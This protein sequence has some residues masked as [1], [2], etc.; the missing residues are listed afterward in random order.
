MSTVKQWVKRCAAHFGIVLDRRI[1]QF[2][3]QRRILPT[4]CP[5]IVDIG[6]F[7]GAVVKKYR[8]HFPD[9]TI[10][11][12]EPCADEYRRLQSLART[13]PLII[14][15]RKAVADTVG[16]RVLHVNRYHQTNSLYEPDPSANVYWQEGTYDLHS[17]VSVECTT[18]D[19]LA[20]E[21]KLDTINIVKIDAQ[22]AELA[23]LHGAERLF[24]EGRIDLVY[25]EVITCPTYVGQASFAEVVAFLSRHDFD[26]WD[27]YDP[28]RGHGK[29]KSWIPRLLQA[30]ML[31]F[32]RRLKLPGR[33]D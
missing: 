17:R 26:L 29:R 32:S 18:L 14:P 24:A 22:G 9:A 10:Y 8:Q 19:A 25:L 31:F 1:D 28:I 13:D 33:L 30:D 2:E 15:V 7:D 4:K 12:V 16:D 27:I 11:A 23:I 6:A 20:A 21:E 3:V 5:T